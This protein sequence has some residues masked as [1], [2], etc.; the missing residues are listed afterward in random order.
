MRFPYVISGS[1]GDSRHFYFFTD[2]P[3]RSRKLEH[4]AEKFTGKDGKQH[5]AWE[6]ELFGTGKQVACPPSIH[7]DTGRAYV[8]GRSIDF[9]LIDLAVVP[10]ETVQG[11]GVSAGDI[12]E[13]DDDLSAEVHR[14][15]WISTMTRS[16]ASWP[17]CRWT[18][19]ARIARAG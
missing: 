9:D 18:N 1:G 10:A 2:R 4:S 17:T 15:R 6:I 14:R 8:W 3:F 19:T 12:V 5:W 11:W 16:K 13:D 7:P